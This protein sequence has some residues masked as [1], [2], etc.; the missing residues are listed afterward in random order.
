MTK[1]QQPTYIMLL[2]DGET[3]TNL[4]ECMVI[5]VPAEFSEDTENIEEFLT[6]NNSYDSDESALFERS[7]LGIFEELGE[8]FRYTSYSK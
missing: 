8:G 1:N 3:F 5:R 4:S 7:I 2:N 6:F